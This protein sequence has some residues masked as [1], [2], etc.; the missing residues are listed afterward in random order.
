MPSIYLYKIY[1]AKNFH[2]IFGL[3]CQALALYVATLAIVIGIPLESSN[4]WAALSGPPPAGDADALLIECLGTYHP[5]NSSP[6]RQFFDERIQPYLDD[7]HVSQFVVGQ[8][9]IRVFIERHR[10]YFESLF[11]RMHPG[12]DAEEYAFFIEQF[13]APPNVEMGTFF[14]KERFGRNEPFPIILFDAAFDGEGIT[15]VADLI[16]ALQ[17]YEI[18]R[19]ACM[20]HGMD[21][22]TF[23]LN[24]KRF[25][26]HHLTA[27]KLTLE[28]WA[29]DHILTD[30]ARARIH[31]SSGFKAELTN[32]YIR[33]YRMLERLVEGRYYVIDPAGN[34]FFIETPLDLELARAQ[35]ARM[36][37][38]LSPDP[39]TGRFTLVPADLNPD[40]DQN[41]PAPY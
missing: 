12:G 7:R 11:R 32:N 41:P 37:Y 23:R 24:R 26:R 35:L 34:P 31:I 36:H 8:G 27:V 6:L 18:P 14:F 15:T 39:D 17:N 21:F 2:E 3:I 16:A 22:G 4:T 29:I 38:G 1:C 10:P 33:Y 19:L 20:G 9:E 28:C 40:K 25:L 13:V 5:S 30:A